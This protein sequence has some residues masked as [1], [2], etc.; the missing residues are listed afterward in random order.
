MVSNMKTSLH[1]LLIHHYPNYTL[2]FKDFESKTA[3]G[4]FHTFPSCELVAKTTTEELTKILK[5]FNKSV[6]KNKAQEIL[7]AIA[8]NGWTDN[9]YQEERNQ[10]I[11]SY[12]ETINHL[13][14]E[15]TLLEEHLDKL[16]EETGYPLKT[17]KG[18]DTV[19][20][21]TFIANIGEISR[22]KHQ[23]QIAKLAGISPWEHSSGESQ[24]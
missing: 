13:D 6:P 17:I 21:A 14:K 2:F 24:N 1:N 5:S 4:F 11:R 15:I 20:A 16:I 12:L 23:S 8:L 7:D 3:R 9:G 18:V 22:F 19:L 10:S